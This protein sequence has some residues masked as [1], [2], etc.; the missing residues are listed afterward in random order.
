MRVV[1]F[2]VLLS[3]DMSRRMHLGSERHVRHNIMEVVCP[4][5]LR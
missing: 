2:E 5:S 3:G 4:D 1:A